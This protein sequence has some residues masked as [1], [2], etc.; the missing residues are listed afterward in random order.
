LLLQASDANASASQAAGKAL[1][2]VIERAGAEGSLA[3]L[4]AC[5]DAGRGRCA[6]ALRKTQPELA[7]R[8]EAGGGTMVSEDAAAY[9]REQDDAASRL[10]NLRKSVKSALK[11]DTRDDDEEP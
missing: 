9:A 5:P 10:Q 3:A 11:Q 8:W 2:A 4:S 6:A 7:A 1:A